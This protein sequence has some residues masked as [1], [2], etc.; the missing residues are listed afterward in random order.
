[1]CKFSRG[2]CD[3]LFEDFESSKVLPYF[4]NNKEMTPYF[5]QKKSKQAKA[6]YLLGLINCSQC[7]NPRSRERSVEKERM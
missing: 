6:T 7:F 1:M 5:L 3:N 2:L 4:V